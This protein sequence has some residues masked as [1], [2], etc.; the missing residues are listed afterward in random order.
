MDYCSIDGFSFSLAGQK[1]TTTPRRGARSMCPTP[2]IVCIEVRGGYWTPPCG[3][4]ANAS[5]RDSRRACAI[6]Y[7]RYSCVMSKSARW[8]RMRAVADARGRPA[9][10]AVASRLS[11]LLRAVA[12]PPLLPLCPS[13]SSAH[14]ERRHWLVH[15]SSAHK[16]WRL[17]VTATS[18]GPH[19]PQHNEGHTPRRHAWGTVPDFAAALGVHST[20]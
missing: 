7:Y 15:L 18:R 3:A 17:V 16:R 13:P 20:S 6:C 11:V 19:A 12:L 4:Y 14:R 1:Q 9:S 2:C 5:H 8:C 10:L